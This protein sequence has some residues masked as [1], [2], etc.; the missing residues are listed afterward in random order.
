[1]Q[2]K[3]LAEGNSRFVVLLFCL[4]S[5]VSSCDVINPDEQIPAYVHIEPYT[6][7]TDFFEGTSS[8]R[9]TEAWFYAN[10][11][12]LGAY[13]L[14]ADIPVLAEG[15]AELRIFPGIKDNGIISTPDI[16]PFY[17]TIT[18]TV[19]LVPAQ[20]VTIN[21]IAEYT[22]NTKF[23][24]IEEFENAHVFVDDQDGDPGTGISISD[25]DVF[26]GSTSG[27]IYLDT[28]HT[29]VEVATLTKYTGIPTNG[30]PVYLEMNYKNEVAFSVGLIGHA[31][32]LD[33]ATYYVITLVPRDF[34]NKIYINLT[35]AML[36]SDL[37]A[38][39]VVI[40]AGL[41]GNLEEAEL[42]FDNI[43]LLHFE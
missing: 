23:V 27:R 32:T 15:Q 8:S 2:K 18:T 34:W 29:L 40:Q 6:V 35:E 42:F 26:E 37:D 16:Y 12:Y 19:D 20:T 21:P 17:T 5:L 41:P 13:G 38:Y 1:M 25:I 9:I 22:A 36:I 28:M 30:S 31:G 39:Q 10:G 4:I 7:E 3:C 14:P 33:P 43:K 24:F 11:E